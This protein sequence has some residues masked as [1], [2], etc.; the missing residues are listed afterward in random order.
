MSK[1]SVTTTTLPS[2]LAPFTGVNN[3]TV[4]LL[5]A[6]TAF[7]L[8]SLRGGDIVY[9]ESVRDYW[10]WL[11]TSALTDDTATEVTI[12]APTVVGVGLGRF[13]RLNIASPDW[14]GGSAP[15]TEWHISSAGN[16]EATG[17]AGSPL[18]TT[19]E[20]QRRWG[21]SRSTDTTSF[22]VRYLTD[23]YIDT[24]DLT[25]WG[26]NSVLYIHGSVNDREGVTPPLATGTATTVQ[27]QNTA[28]NTPWAIDTASFA[29]WAG[30]S[31]KRIRLTSGANIHALSWA[32]LQDAVTP[33]KSRTTD[34]LTPIAN[35]TVSPFV[36]PANTDAGP[37]NGVTFV[38]ENLRIVTGL[39]FDANASQQTAIRVV[40]DSLQAGSVTGN[41][42]INLYSDGCTI[43]T[44]ACKFNS[45]AVHNCRANNVLDTTAKVIVGGFNVSSIF[46][47]SGSSVSTIDKYT[48]QGGITGNIQ[49]LSPPFTASAAGIASWGVG[50]IG[51]FDGVAGGNGIIFLST[52]AELRTAGGGVPA[53]CNIYGNTAGPYL[54]LANGVIVYYD[55]AIFA[56]PMPIVATGTSAVRLGDNPLNLGQRTVAPA[57][58][59]GVT[60]LP[61]AERNITIANIIATVAAGGFGN[62]FVDPI[63]GAGFTMH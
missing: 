49:L 24:F 48:I 43:S 42:R 25:Q 57:F 21:S 7:E 9:V 51:I 59:A 35:Y 29:S 23:N 47:S 6:I 33:S 19:T 27:T 56:L 14:I 37:V 40:L 45:H 52:G 41:E 46:T 39:T 13:E 38:V 17:L 8:N 26:T 34:W 44:T 4:R 62:S 55:R 11:P 50:R 20:R 1:V 53:T 15:Q 2:K 36:T 22:H 3:G 12:C 60:N 61:T 28:T 10:K 58:D 54:M 32:T 16:N 63:T 30:L 31:Q 5:K 18:L